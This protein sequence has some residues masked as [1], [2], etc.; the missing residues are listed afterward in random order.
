MT[1]WL[2]V[3]ALELT[4]AELT[5]GLRSEGRIGNVP[6]ITTQSGQGSQTLGSATTLSSELIPNIAF[7]L[8]TRTN[9]LSAVYQP[10]LLVTRSFGTTR[11]L[12]LHNASIAYQ[13]RLTRKLSLVTTAGGT[14]G[15]LDFYRARR[16]LNPEQATVLT[17]PE[18]G[19]FGY[20]SGN[21]YVGL[22]YRL[23]RFT[24][25]DGGAIVAHTGPTSGQGTVQ[26]FRKQDSAGA[27]GRLSHDF[28]QFNTAGFTGEY[29]WVWFEGGPYYQSATPEAFVR[30]RFSRTF[31]LE[32][33]GGLMLSG[34]R[35]GSLQ[36]RDWVLGEGL[37][38]RRIGT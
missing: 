29:R 2:L 11:T 22:A 16:Q 32:V 15:N 5:V 17:V 34:T 23:A 27:T 24:R 36:T 6:L 30:H 37:L 13:H 20:A 21:A 14:I 18:N 8:K 3:I 4:A 33:H 28:D 38:P 1:L 10:Q 31:G 9:E 25:L 19:V 35:Y 26:Y 7:R 12:G